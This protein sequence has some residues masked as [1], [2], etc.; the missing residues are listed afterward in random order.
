M[1]D[2]LFFT[3]LAE[4]TER[5]EGTVDRAPARLKSR[6]YSALVAG[7]ASGGPLRSLTATK[8][9]G[10]PLC[11]FENLLQLLPAGERVDS[12]NLCRVCHARVLG[13]QFESPPIYWPHCP[14]V[15]FRRR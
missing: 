8:A 14:Y 5:V 15:D 11:V 6:L 9:A 2:E 12:M 4:T 13:E 1:N 3:R 7:Q 10:R